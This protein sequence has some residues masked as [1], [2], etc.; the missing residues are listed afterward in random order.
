MSNKKL[1]NINKMCEIRETDV[2]CS[3]LINMWNKR[4]SK[5]YT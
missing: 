1:F 3:T 5:F 2:N 4:F